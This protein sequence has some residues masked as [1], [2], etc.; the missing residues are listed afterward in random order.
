MVSLGFSRGKAQDTPVKKKKKKSFR[1]LLL[2]FMACVSI[3]FLVW[4]IIPE[5]A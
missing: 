1:D 2:D 3:K 5:W 4:L